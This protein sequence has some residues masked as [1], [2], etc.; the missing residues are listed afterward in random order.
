MAEKIGIVGAGVGGLAAA[1][2]L[3][4]RGYAVEVYEK[5]PNC[6]GRNNLLEDK[7]FKFDM[8][9]SFVLMPDF[10]EELFYYCGENLKDYLDFKVLDVNYKI[11]YPDGDSLIVYQD[12]QRTKEELEKLEAGSSIAYDRFIKEGARIYNLVK[13]LLYRCLT[14]KSLLGLRYWPA[15]LSLRPVGSCWHLARRFFKSE[16]LC[17]AFTFEAMFMGVS[18]YRL[19]AFYNIINYSGHIQKVRH[20]MGGMYQIP[21][22]LEKLAKKFQAQFTYNERIKR[23]S[24]DRRKIILEMADKDSVVDKAV[25]NADYPYAQNVLLGRE[26]P[27]YK[28]SSSVYLL[29][30]GL[31]KKVE[32][33]KHH[34]LFFSQDMKMNLRQIFKDKVIPDDP[35]FYVGVPTVT[36][37]SLAAPDKDLFYI[38]IPV[39]NLDNVRRDINK[40][41]DRL[42]RVVFEKINKALSVNLEDLIEVEHRFYPSDFIER[43]NLNYG[44]AFGLAH[45]LTQSAFFRPPN[46]DAKIKNLY[47]VGASTQPGSGLPVV[48]ASSKIVADMIR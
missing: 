16:K 38:L 44:A 35:C 7:G 41:Q 45:H 2:R 17:S 46:F 6:G 42:R 31:K 47:F 26:I 8:G 32:G 1:A 15:V 39:P 19:P 20:P 5:L 9:P 33:L 4:K 48:I 12:S 3:A 36:D 34:N 37:P 23:I 28:Y 25:I 27:R 21:L 10:F 11:F 40:E 43:Y 30:L 18:P 13:P 29:Y 22:A 24:T 14:K